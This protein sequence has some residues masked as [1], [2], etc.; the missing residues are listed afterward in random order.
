MKPIQ[1]SAEMLRKLHVITV[2]SNPV[3]FHSRYE[4]YNNFKKHMEASGAQLHTVELAFGDRPFEITRGGCGSNETQFRTFDELWHKENMINLA[5]ARL[6]TDWEY[7][8]WIDADIM[9]QNPYW[10]AETVQQLQHHMVV[11]L[12][13]QAVDLGPRHEI[14]QTHRGFVKGYFDE[15]FKC[16]NMK[17]K[18]WG[19]YGYG[20][21]GSFAHPGYAWAARREALEHTGGLLE[22]AILGSGDHHMAMALIGEAAKT[23]PSNIHSRYAFKIM[24]WQDRAVRYLHRDIGFVDGTLLHYWHGKKIDR[25]YRGRWVILDEYDPDL[26]IKRDTQGLFV[27][28]DNNPKLRDGIRMYFRNRNED[29]IDV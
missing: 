2:I 6:P 10:L 27:L 18:D 12:F 1:P 11:Q 14:M 15:G 17:H 3:R 23:F 25:N 24:Q 13:A 5:L 8:A 22:F 7:V 29:S 21:T 26:D 19:Y 9:F 28:T 4:L 20:P 16:P